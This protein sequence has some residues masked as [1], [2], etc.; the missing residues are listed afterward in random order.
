MKKRDARARWCSSSARP[1]TRTSRARR[2]PSLSNRKS[3]ASPGRR[4][5]EGDMSGKVVYFEDV[6]I[7]DEITPLP[8]NPTHETIAAYVQACRITEKRFTDDAYA[9]NLGMD[10]IIAPGNMGL[11]YLSRMINDWAQGAVLRKLD[12]RFRGFVKP[13]MLLTCR[14][15]IVAKNMRGSE[16]SIECDVFIENENGDRPVAGSATVILP[17]RG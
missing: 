10:G 4:V 17:M 13:G 1:P 2:S 5:S 9:R 15:L 3:D 16:E 12:V 8:M 6:D 7:G 11:A 14:G